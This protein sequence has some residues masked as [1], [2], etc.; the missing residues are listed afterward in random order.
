MPNAPIAVAILN[1]NGKKLLERFLAN[2]LEHSSP[3]AKVYLIDNNS[4]DD[5][6]AYTKAEFPAVE[7]ISLADNYGYAGGYNKGLKH[8]E[9][10]IVILL[11]SDVEVSPNW[12][13]PLYSRFTA[14]AT[15]AALQPKIKDL[16]S[17]QHF[18]YA[19]AAGGYIDILGYPFCRG[20]IFDHLEKDQ[21]QYNNYQEVFW[22][23]GACLAVR[24]SAFEQVGKLYETLFAHMEEID[25]CWRL[26]LAGFKVAVEPASEVYH[27]GGATLESYSPQKTYLNFRNSL[28]ILF[29]NLPHSHAIPTIL[30]RLVLDGVSAIRF[31]LSGKPKLLFAILRAHFAFYGMFNALFLEKRKRKSAPLKSLKG[32]YPKSI[33]A[34]FYLR[35]R[36]TYNDLK[37]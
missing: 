4:S 14:D 28:I 20:R 9:E 37:F 25:L 10:E 32:V 11:N 35:K 19:G 24:K 30:A 16:K 2:V 23:T 22:A 12:L 29:L 34:A 26:Q 13:E 6:I 27:L 3:L 15:L 1:W 8:I 36:K 18:E 7:I 33:V 21:Q 17:P 31:L 5:S